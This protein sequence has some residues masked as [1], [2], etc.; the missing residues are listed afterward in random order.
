MA[1][2]EFSKDLALAIAASLP[3]G[4]CLV[5]RDGEI[6]Y[7]NP[8][9][10]SIFG[11]PKDGLSECF[12]E[13]L[14][15][16]DARPAHQKLRENY[17]NKPL[18]TAMGGGRLLTGLKKS[19]ETVQLQ[20]GLT[21]LSDQYTLVS[22]IE[23]TNKIIK[24]SNSNDPLTGL[25]N[26]KKFDE[27]SKKLRTLAVRNK[28]NIAIA[29]IDLDDFKAINDL[30]GHHIGDLVICEVAKILRSHIRGS[31]MVARI[32]GDEFI[33]CFYDIGEHEYLKTILNQLVRQIAQIKTI[34]GNAVD[35]GASAGA[36]MTFT[37]EKVSIAEMINITDKLM[38]QAKKSGKG[39]VTIN[40]LDASNFKNYQ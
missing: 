14:I 8:K 3:I 22:L 37:P 19:G 27:Y 20:I 39:M 11:Y 17:A 6:M 21:P 16:K 31:D 4:I 15:P 10:E 13:D 24:P 18:D 40:E 26:R 25:A 32:G 29:F 34:E 9:A 1:K 33:L 35:I 7:A 36:I 5:A 23:T 30:F 38:Y 12:V 28:K 2:I